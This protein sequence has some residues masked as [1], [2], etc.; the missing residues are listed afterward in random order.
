M[1]G[2]P[3]DLPG[4]LARRHPQPKGVLFV[5]T[6]ESRMQYAE[7]MLKRLC[8][9]IGPHPSGT[10]EFE[11]VV[12]IVHEDLRTSIADVQLDRY[13][14]FWTTL[15]IPEICHKGRRLTVGVAENCSGTTDAG[16]DGIIRA[17][18]WRPLPLPHRERRER[19]A[20]GPHPGQP[21]RG[22]GARLPL[23]RR[24]PLP[25]EVRRRHP[26]RP[27]P[28]PAREGRGGGAGAPP[29]PLRPRAADPQ[30]RGP[31]PRHG[32]R[33]GSSSWPTPTP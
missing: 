22:G 11:E 1:R 32:G 16:F 31:H 20:R 23:R 24:R 14:D 17:A 33:R 15:P 29:R 5:D 12:R 3:A 13:L 18:C 10:P 4:A 21:R 6:P 8:E 19:P 2:G 9:E 28:R 25:S 26:R 30:H 7:G 27:L